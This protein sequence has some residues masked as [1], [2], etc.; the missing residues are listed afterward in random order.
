[1]ERLGHVRDLASGTDAEHSA[2]KNDLQVA[3]T[4]WH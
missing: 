3:S 2:E 1:M 4:P